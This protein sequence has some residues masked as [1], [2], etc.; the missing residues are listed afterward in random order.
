MY[1]NNSTES[2]VHIYIYMYVYTLY[3]R[4]TLEFAGCCVYMLTVNILIIVRVITVPLYF[5]TG[6]AISTTLLV[7]LN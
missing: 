2:I 4:N 7:N 1:N 3:C 6:F 5:L